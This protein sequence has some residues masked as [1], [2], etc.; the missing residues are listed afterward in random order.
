MFKI[1]LTAAR[2]NAGF[3]LDDVAQKI[4]KTKGTIIAWEKGKTSIDVHNFKELCDLYN[5]P[6]EFIILPSN[7][8]QSGIEQEE[9]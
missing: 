2:V 9:I 8:T 4:H 6:M 3:T 5:V 1:T 7:S